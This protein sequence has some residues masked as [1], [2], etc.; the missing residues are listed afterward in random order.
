MT[1]LAASEFNLSLPCYLAPTPAGAFYAVQGGVKDNVGRYLLFLLAQDET[2]LFNEQHLQHLHE[3]ND[4]ALQ[5]LY[6][7]QQLGYIQA[8]EQ[9]EQA[10]QGALE[11]VLP[12]YLDKLSSTGKVIL[13][14]EQGFYLAM[15]GFVHENAEELSALSAGLHEIYQRHK[16]LLQNNLGVKTSALGLID[17]AGNS[18]VG[19]WPLF[20]ARTRFSLIIAD[21]PRF[22]SKEFVQIINYLAIRYSR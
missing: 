16:A 15:S 10:A 1:V 14:D 11:D 21:V 8:L 7:L 6:R 22:N 12:K 3:D 2:P 9:P 18:E 4:T 17:V 20:F 19:F 5:I 13:S